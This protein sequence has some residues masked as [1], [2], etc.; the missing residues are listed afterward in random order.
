M[1]ANAL[2]KLCWM[3]ANIEA[4]RL[5]AEEILPIHFLLA[6]MK[7]IDPMFPSMLDKLDVGSDEWAAMCK[8]AT[9]VRRYIDVMPDRVT[10]KRHRIRARLAK[11]REAQ[12]VEGDGFLHRSKSLKRAFEDA[13]MFSEK[14]EELTLL[15]LIESMFELELVS[16]DDVDR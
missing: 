6:T 13:M 3:I 16:L 7:I 15:K 12:P 8:E 2:L 11:D 9:S 14:A 10:I 5:G 1:R 4:K